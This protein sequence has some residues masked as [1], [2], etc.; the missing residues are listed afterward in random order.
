MRRSRLFLILLCLTIS[1]FFGARL[2][3]A[4][5]ALSIDEAATRM[6]VRKPALRHLGT[7]CAIHDL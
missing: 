2:S 1:L 4:N 7:D 5:I 3:S 6:A